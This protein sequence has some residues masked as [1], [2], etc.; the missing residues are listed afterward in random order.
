M[1]IL[2]CCLLLSCASVVAQPMTDVRANLIANAIFKIEGGTKTKHPYG[3]LSIKT[4]NP[5][6]V[7][8]NTIKNNYIR[9]Q[10]A[11][12]HGDF[13]EFLGNRYCPCK[14]GVTILE[15]QCNK[16]WLPNLRKILRAKTYEQFDKNMQ[17]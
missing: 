6:Q 16:Y 15:T 12:G 7:C 4:N 2:V 8:I 13:F 14:K 1:K 17:N 5:R 9:W 10:E 3:I 11:G